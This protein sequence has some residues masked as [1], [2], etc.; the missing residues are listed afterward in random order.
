MEF[1]VIYKKRNTPGNPGVYI[2]LDP[3]NNG[4]S[5]NDGLSNNDRLSGKIQKLREDMS[6]LINYERKY[7]LEEIFNLVDELVLAYKTR[8]AYR[9][10]SIKKETK[11]LIGNL[12]ILLDNASII[13]IDD[14]F[15]TLLHSKID[16]LI[17]DTYHD[18]TYEDIYDDILSRLEYNI[19]DFLYA[20]SRS[21]KNQG[22]GSRRRSTQRKRTPRRR[23]VV[24]T[25]KKRY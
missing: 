14:E 24:Q 22:G 5:K 2:Y 21:L 7:L 23:K 12:K 3:T 13:V 20:Y 15:D 17:R 1:K 16:G 8:S 10:F 25:R 19:V 6:E 11:K 9:K 18:G 4:L